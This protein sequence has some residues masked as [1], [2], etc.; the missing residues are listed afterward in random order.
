[1]P[2]L[3]AVDRRTPLILG[4]L[5]LVLV[6][7][8]LALS[9]KILGSP[10]DDPPADRVVSATS[11][12][13]DEEAGAGSGSTAATV[14]SS[15][16]APPE[17]TAPVVVSPPSSSSSPATAPAVALAD[18]LVAVLDGYV[19]ALD[20]GDIESAYAYVAP[21]LRRQ[22]GWDL[23]RFST[24]WTESV[25]GAVVVS[26]DDVSPSSG[27]VEATIDYFLPDG[28]TSREDVVATFASAGDAGVL[29]MVDYEVIDTERIG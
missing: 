21:S 3:S 17:A 5:V 7:A 23:D 9:F 28:A 25:V 22:D 26:V 12:A 27:A 8:V 18:E 19:A 13:A 2:P 4:G 20:A 29:V 6:V 16:D 15:T 24:F 11:T 10:Q 1:M 14:P